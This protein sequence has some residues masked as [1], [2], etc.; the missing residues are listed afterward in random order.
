MSG[1]EAPRNRGPRAS[2]DLTWST[3]TD[4]IVRL[5]DDAILDQHGADQLLESIYP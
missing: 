4:G 1:T 5:H 2:S 3:T